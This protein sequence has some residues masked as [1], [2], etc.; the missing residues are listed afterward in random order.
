MKKEAQMKIISQVLWHDSQIKDIR[1]LQNIFEE[2]AYLVHNKKG[3]KQILED[4]AI[5]P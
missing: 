4:L 1:F 3:R 2:F 5:K